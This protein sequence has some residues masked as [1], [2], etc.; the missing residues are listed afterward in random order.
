M[1]VGMMTGQ[2]AGGQRLGRRRR[3]RN[4]MPVASRPKS[5]VRLGTLPLPGHR[6]GSMFTV[7]E[8][9]QQW[10]LLV[11]GLVFVFR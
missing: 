3:K 11:S 5:N 7:V 1:L 10:T 4:T 8:V 9:L 6:P 2:V